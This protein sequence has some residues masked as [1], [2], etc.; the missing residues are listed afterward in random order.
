MNAT[1]KATVHLGDDHDVNSR[2][3]QSSL[4]DVQEN[5]SVRQK[6]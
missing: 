1:L 5:Y 4:E 6:S 2:H 3:V